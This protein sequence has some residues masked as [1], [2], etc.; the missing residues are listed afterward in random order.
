M[1][2]GVPPPSISILPDKSA[3][4]IPEYSAE[5]HYEPL[6]VMPI[7]GNTADD[8]K[9]PI[10]TIPAPNLSLVDAPYN[11]NYPYNGGEYRRNSSETE[12][13]SN[14]GKYL[15]FSLFCVFCVLFLCINFVNTF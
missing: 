11:P 13:H 7:H 1:R 8:D 14:A 6:A 2:G 3:P 12:Y 4:R 15:N 9:G 10:H 5:Y